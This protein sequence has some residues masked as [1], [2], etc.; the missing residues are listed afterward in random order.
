MGSTKFL[1]QPLRILDEPVV[2]LRAEVLGFKPASDG[3]G[4]QVQPKIV[5]AIPYYAWANRD[6]FEMQMW[7]P[8]KISSVA[9][10]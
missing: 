8:T 7:L 9:I 10:D 2:S 6:N 1:E 5:T 4:V 3:R